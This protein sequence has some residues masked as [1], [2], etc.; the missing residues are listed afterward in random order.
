MRASSIEF[1]LRMLI[2]IV[3]VFL[4]FWAP[5]IGMGDLGRR[6]ATLEWLALELSRARIASFTYAA[7]IVIVLGALAALAGAVLRVWGAAYL[8]YD[9]VHHLQMQAAKVVAA[10]PYR[11]V[12]NPL[13][14]GGWFMMAAISLLMPPTGALFTMALVTVFYLRLILGEEAFL[15]GQIGEPYREYLRAVPRL[16][17]RLRPRLPR[18]P[19]HPNWLTALL[20]EINPIGIFITLAILSWTYN[21]LLMIKAVLISFGISLV[22]RAF[23]P[24]GEI[25]ASAA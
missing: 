6:V 5:W 19:A 21:N 25:K 15:A 20:T 2:R 18:A 14:L 22:V 16:I 3:I 13:Y 10:G 24:R 1:R 4:G 11:Y 23:M 7:P 12:R 9:I 17:P 8:G